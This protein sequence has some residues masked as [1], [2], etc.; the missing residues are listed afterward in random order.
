MRMDAAGVIEMEPGQRVAGFTGPV[1][2]GAALGKGGA[3]REDDVANSAVGDKDVRRVEIFEIQSDQGD[4]FA[5]FPVR[6]VVVRVVAIE[7]GVGKLGAVALSVWTSALSAEMPPGPWQERHRASTLAAWSS[8]SP[9]ARW[10][11]WQ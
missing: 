3:V 1:I 9:S 4:I 8:V 2:I 10:V 5:A 11:V 6:E 7:A